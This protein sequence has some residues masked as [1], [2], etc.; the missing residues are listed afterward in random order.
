[1]QFQREFSKCRRLIDISKNKR[2]KTGVIIFSYIPTRVH[3]FSSYEHYIFKEGAHAARE[4]E[5]ATRRTYITYSILVAQLREAH[6]S[7]TFFRAGRAVR[8]RKISRNESPPRRRRRGTYWRAQ[9]AARTSVRPGPG[10]VIRSTGQFFFN[11]SL[12]LSFSPCLSLGIFLSCSL[13]Y[14]LLWSFSSTLPSS[15][16]LA[17]RP[18]ARQS[19]INLYA[20]RVCTPLFLAVPRNL[21]E[22]SRTLRR[23]LQR[24]L[25]AERTRCRSCRCDH[26]DDD[27]DDGDNHN[28]VLWYF[29]NE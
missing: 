8:A 21:Q 11:Y 7:F 6:R 3:S 1:M 29:L 19:G 23:L 20:V 12:S 28:V 9:E 16:P 14:S 25:T 24:G 22:T 13:S 2:C 4:R 5:R 17:C 10:L 18:M 15:A 26:D 27:D